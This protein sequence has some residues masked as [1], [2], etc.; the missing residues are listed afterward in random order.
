[1]SR[2]HKKVNAG[3]FA[4]CRSEADDKK[5][6]HKAYRRRNRSNLANLPEN[7]EIEFAHIRQVSDPW[8]MGK[9]GKFLHYTEYDIRRCINASLNALLNG[10]KDA[11]Y[12]WPLDFLMEY[13]N[14]KKPEE[15]FGLSVQ[16]IEEF[17]RVHLKKRKRK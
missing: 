17:V 1:M 2:S 8:V 7:D 15:L 6:W 11:K 3:G 4:S 13:C 14:L 10:E 9:D 16:Q 5:I 12:N